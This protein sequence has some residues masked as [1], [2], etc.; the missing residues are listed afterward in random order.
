MLIVLKVTMSPRTL[1]QDPRTGFFEEKLESSPDSGT[2]S[3]HHSNHENVI[4]GEEPE[5]E[6]D[7]DNNDS[8]P[9]EEQRIDGG[10][11][12]KDSGP[13][14]PVGFW[15]KRMNKVRLQVVG[16]WARTGTHEQSI[17]NNLNHQL[18]I[19][20]SPDAFDVY[21][22]GSVNVLGCAVPCP[23]KHII[24]ECLRGGL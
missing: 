21:S 5:S 15:D 24:P 8:I 2:L 19:R 20:Y 23:A 7:H 9:S 3:D 4:C 10:E 6:G 17:E 16:L 18:T 13:P 12:G 11:K 1:V 14:K 22:G